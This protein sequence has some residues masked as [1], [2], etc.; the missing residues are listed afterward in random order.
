MNANPEFPPLDIYEDAEQAQLLSR[1]IELLYHDPRTERVLRGR[2]AGWHVEVACD[3][4]LTHSI[5][6]GNEYNRSDVFWLHP[7]WRFFRATP[8]VRVVLSS[9]PLLPWEPS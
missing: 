5:I 8:V 6:Q 1:R 3:D 7:W 2:F 9:A 4:L